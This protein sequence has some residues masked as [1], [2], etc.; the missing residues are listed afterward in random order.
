MKTLIQCGSSA[1]GILDARN[2][3][4]FDHTK[5][6]RKTRKGIETIEYDYSYFSRLDQ[7]VREVARL[8][9]NEQADDLRDWLKKFTATAN[10]LTGLFTAQGSL[11]DLQDYSLVKKPE[12]APSPHAPLPMSG[13]SEQKQIGGER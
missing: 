4:V 10:E 11:L 9:A 7:A 12:K 1:I 3:V 13:R 8:A 6:R 2:Y 5:P